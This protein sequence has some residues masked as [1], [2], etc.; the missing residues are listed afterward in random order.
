MFDKING[1]LLRLSVIITLILFCGKVTGYIN[2][3]WWAVPF[4]VLLMSSFNYLLTALSFKTML[5]IS[6]R[7]NSSE[8]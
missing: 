6:S 1:I 2:T 8:V 4:P 3:S 7:R 5:D